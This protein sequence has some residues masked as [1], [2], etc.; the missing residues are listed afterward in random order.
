[1]KLV[2]ANDMVQEVPFPS[3]SWV[4]SDIR[5]ITPWF[6][7]HRSTN[8]QTRP[9]FRQRVQGED[10]WHCSGNEFHPIVDFRVSDH[11]GMLVPIDEPGTHGR[12]TD[13][14]DTEHRFE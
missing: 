5:D 3:W 1:M 2:T 4:A 12:W 9:T 8:W 6:D 14:Y 7:F 13:T 11:S 10:T